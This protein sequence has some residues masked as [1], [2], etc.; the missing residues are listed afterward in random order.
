MVYLKVET[1]LNLNSYLAASYCLI[2]RRVSSIVL[3][4]RVLTDETK[5]L[6]ALSNVSPFFVKFLW[7]SEL[8]KNSSWS[9]GDF[10]AKS[11]NASPKAC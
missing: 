11:E 10:W 8:Y 5:K 1:L 2:V 4:H 7:V 6:R 3:L 9:S